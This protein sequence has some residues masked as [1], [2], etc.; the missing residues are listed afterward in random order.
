MQF[1]IHTLLL[2]LLFLLV[3]SAFFSSS[4]IAMLSLNRYRLRFLVKKN[5]RQAI[6]VNH[7]LTRPERL[8]SVVLIGNTL[9]NILASMVATIVGQRLYG[10]WGVAVVTAVLTVI[11]LVFS[12]MAPKTLAAMYP[13]KV[14]FWLSL[15]LKILMNIF[16]PLVRLLSGTAN[17]VLR[18]CG[19]RLSEVAKEA[20]TGEE[21]RLVV[22]EAALLLPSEHKTMLLS[23]LDL[24]QVTVEDIMVLKGDIVG[25]NIDQPWADIVEQLESS[26]HTRLPLYRT[27]IDDLVGMVH[28]R[29][30]LNLV[31][32]ETF[33]MEHLLE[34]AEAPYFIPE[35]TPLNIQILN[36]QKMKRR[37]CFVVNEYGD[38]QGLAT[39]EDILEEIVG[40]FTTDVAALSKDM[41]L[42]EDG[43]VIVDGGTTIRTLNRLLT[44]QLPFIGPRTLSGLVIEHLGYIPPADCC[45]SIGHYRLEVLKVSDN[46]IKSIRM[47]KATK[48]RQDPSKG[49]F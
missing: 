28:V 48:Y 29:D 49:Y 9:A 26:Q 42:Q 10:D 30:V 43:S 25:I 20:L 31:L 22:H 8:L 14:S 19:V 16:S 38:L 45:V 27:R 5:N 24:E 15:P 40:E 39:M 6:R 1:S 23:L 4:E 7:M 3:I 35:G 41:T 36:F 12:E 37:S 32:D 44:W 47:W 13:E 11:I 46:T 17:L 21:L 34:A 33:D 18:L 2:I